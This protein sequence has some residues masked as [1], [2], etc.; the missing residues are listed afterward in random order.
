LWPAGCYIDGIWY[1]IHTPWAHN[2][3]GTG[4]YDEETTFGTVNNAYE[5]WMWIDFDSNYN[6]RTS[7]QAT[8][9]WE[10]NYWGDYRE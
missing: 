10:N 3:F 1:S 5:A 6:P 2:P 8:R 7:P 4:Y 9:H